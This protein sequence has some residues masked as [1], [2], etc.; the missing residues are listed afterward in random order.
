[1]AIG[2]VH[3]DVE[4]LIG[5]LD[6]TKSLEFDVVVF[7]GDFIDFGL[8]PKGFERNDIARLIIAEL[9][10]LKKPIIAVPGN[11]DKDV[12][13]IMEKEGINLHGKG[14]VIDGVGFYGYGGAKTPFGT[15][16][17]PSEDEIKLGLEKAWKEVKD[18]KIKVQVT[19]IPPAKTKLDMVY[20]GAHVGSD[21][22]RRFIE[23]KQPAVAISAHIHEAKGTD[24]IGKTK[25]INPG[26]F[27]EGYCGLI[28]VDEEKSTVKIVNLI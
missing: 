25:L 1:M 20:T 2:D 10:T 8:T 9:K 15:P 23:E 16:L 14:R 6:K 21:V 12:L 18:C 28:S 4:D 26:R 7:T 24:E 22:V 27:P 13:S 11:H 5:F 3:N 17:E 19:H